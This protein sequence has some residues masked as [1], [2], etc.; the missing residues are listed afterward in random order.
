VAVAELPA[1]PPPTPEIP[2]VAVPPVEAG[3]SAVASGEDVFV[4]LPQPWPTHTSAQTT[5]D[6]QRAR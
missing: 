2:P 5:I 6:D 4:L 1:D 3:A